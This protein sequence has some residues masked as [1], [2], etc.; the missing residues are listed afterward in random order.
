M[1][2]MHVYLCE[3][4]FAH[5]HAHAHTCT[6]GHAHTQRRA[7]TTNTNG[8]LCRYSEQLDNLYFIG[9][10]VGAG[11]FGVVRECVEMSSGKRFAVKSIQKKPKRGPCGCL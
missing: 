4:T 1:D 11:S 10:V 5:M 8:V 6:H 9:R 2:K 7:H 3:F